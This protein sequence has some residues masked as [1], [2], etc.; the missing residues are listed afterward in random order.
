M[1][2]LERVAA[3]RRHL[4]AMQ[5]RCSTGFTWGR[6]V[7]G[8]AQIAPVGASGGARI[9][10]Q[11]A[12]PMP[13]DLPDRLMA[14]LEARDAAPKLPREVAVMEALGVPDT[15]EGAGW[16]AAAWAR[17]ERRDAVR[18]MRGRRDMFL[19]EWLVRLLASGKVLRSAGA[20]MAWAGSEG[21]R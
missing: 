18:L 13:A 12:A 21:G 14:W 19:G 4:V 2:G 5:V 3:D 16:W 6:A 7:N 8:E 15:A 11:P 10:A 17:L 20:P 9:V 1:R